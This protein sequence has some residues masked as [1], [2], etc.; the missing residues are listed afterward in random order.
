MDLVKL[1][2]AFY[3]V[4]IL[5]GGI[6]FYKQNE[7]YIYVAFG[8]VVISLLIFF[9]NYVF[10]TYPRYINSFTQE[11][12]LIGSDEIVLAKDCETK[13]KECVCT[14]YKGWG[15]L[16]EKCA[17]DSYWAANIEEDDC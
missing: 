8:C 16:D 3:L 7:K 13:N 5:F 17:V 10:I 11:A 2:I 9:Y 1:N 14:I 4:A 6:S 12:K 15:T